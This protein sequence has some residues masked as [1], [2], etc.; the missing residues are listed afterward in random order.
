MV[1][2]AL[3]NMFNVTI[4]VVHARQQACTV[5]TTSPT[6]WSLLMQYHFVGLDKQEIVNAS[7]NHDS[8][9]SSVEQ[10]DQPM[11]SQ[12][13]VVYISCALSYL[14]SLILSYS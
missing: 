9:H 5:A 1:I 6:P 10:T 14:H 4:N 3:A 8:M 2:A 13:C 7:E 11:L 12:P